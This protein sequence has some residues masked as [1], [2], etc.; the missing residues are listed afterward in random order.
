[1]CTS[2]FPFE[3]AYERRASYS[4]ARFCG[5]G[6]PSGFLYEV[7]RTSSDPLVAMFRT[8]LLPP[9]SPAEITG[10]MRSAFVTL[11]QDKDFIRDYSTAVKTDPLLVPGADAQEI[12]TR[13][14]KVKPEVKAFVIDYTNKLVK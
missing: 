12:I 2:G 6:K 13:L 5:E 14:G 8:A 10:V 1:M 9:N 3:E 4:S 7:L 11:A